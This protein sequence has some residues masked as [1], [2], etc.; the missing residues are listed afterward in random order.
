MTL[1]QESIKNYQSFNVVDDILAT[2]GTAKCTTDLILSEGK[3]I[4]GYSM[5]I[6]IKSLNG[7]K[8]LLGQVNSQIL[9]W[10]KQ[11]ISR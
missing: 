3:E 8:K 6:E 11:L 10:T 5:V 9:I 2:G 7:R 1:Q 4:T